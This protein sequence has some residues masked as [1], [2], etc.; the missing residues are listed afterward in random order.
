MRGLVK[1]YSGIFNI[2]KV[3]FYRGHRMQNFLHEKSQ[4]YHC[5]CVSRI[6]EESWVHHDPFGIIGPM[7]TNFF[8]N[9]LRI[10]MPKYYRPG[11]C[12]GNNKI[13]LSD[14]KLIHNKTC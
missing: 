4:N 1:L 9:M 2:E 14:T 12:T 11:T 8:Y 3:A 5:Q 7:W 10:T 13:E 6:A